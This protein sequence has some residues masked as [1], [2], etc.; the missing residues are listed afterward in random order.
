MMEGL[1]QGL[2]GAGIAF[3]LVI[4]TRVI[5]SAIA[6]DHDYKLLSQLV[7]SPSQALGTGLFVVLVGVVVGAVG[8]FVAVHRFLD[9]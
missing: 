9:T 6:E 4:A 2:L 8:S 5:M 3:A 7:V 1:L